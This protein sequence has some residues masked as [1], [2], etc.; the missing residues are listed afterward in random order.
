[1]GHPPPCSRSVTILAVRTILA[2]AA[3]MLFA[4]LSAAKDPGAAYQAGTLL[5]V[6]HQD[7]S[8]VVGNSQT[9]TVTSV[10]DREYLISVAVGD[11]TYVGSYWPRWRWSYE[12]TDFIV[13]SE[14]KVRLSKKEMY[15]MRPDGKELQTKIVKR[16]ATKPAPTTTGH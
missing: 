5:D 11:M 4:V 10:A 14:I 8:R 12:P 9:G 1:E 3:V 2:I 13:N 6:T 7:S 16:I 15:I